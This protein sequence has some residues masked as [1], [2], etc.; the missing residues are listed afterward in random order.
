MFGNIFG[1][2]DS[3][4]ISKVHKSIV[5]KR[6][7]GGAISL[8]KIEQKAGVDLR[9]KSEA[10]EKVLSSKGLL[11]IRAQAVLVLDYSGSMGRDYANGSIQ[12]LAERFLAFALQIDADGEVP[13][14]PFASKRLSTINVGLDNYVGVIQRELVAK[15]HMGSTNLADALQEVKRLA[16]STDAPMFVGVVTDGNPDDSYNNFKDTTK[17]VCELAGYPT[18]LKFMALRDVPYLQKLDDLP[19]SQRL[20]DNV[21]SKFYPNLNIS[22]EQFFTDMCEEWPEWVKLA[23]AKGVLK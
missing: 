22:D 3:A 18:F 13:I 2:N 14:I 21:D 19:D 23:T 15:Q 16:G 12:T 11:G 1:S 8:D 17:V 20:L 9:K 10:A 7:T 5:L 4:D 6:E